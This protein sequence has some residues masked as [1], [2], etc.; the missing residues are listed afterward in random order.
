MIRVLQT[1]SLRLAGI[2]FVYQDLGKG[3]MI[4]NECVCSNLKNVDGGMHAMLSYVLIM[5]ITL[6]HS[7]G[8][9]HHKK[10]CPLSH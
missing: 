4:E 8:E 3:D 5:S 9:F 6:V 2:S 1:P 10:D 7:A